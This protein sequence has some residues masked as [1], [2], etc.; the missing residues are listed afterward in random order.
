VRYFQSS[1][2]SDNRIIGFIVE[3]LGGQSVESSI[4]FYCAQSWGLLP[5][6]WFYRKIKGMNILIK[7]MKLA[8]TDL[9]PFIVTR[10][11]PVPVQAPLQPAKVESVSGDALSVTEE[12]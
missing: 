10:H 8:V 9:S 1:V 6:E 12:L 11:V 3:I 4:D 7:E 2:S 5:F